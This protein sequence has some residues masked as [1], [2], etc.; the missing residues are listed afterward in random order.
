MFQNMNLKMYAVIKKV[1]TIKKIMNDK[2][3]Q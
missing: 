2:N 1:I 3:C